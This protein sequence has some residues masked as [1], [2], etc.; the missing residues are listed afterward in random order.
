MSSTVTFSAPNRD[1]HGLPVGSFGPAVRLIYMGDTPLLSSWSA[2]APESEFS[3]TPR[4]N[5]PRALRPRYEKNGT[6]RP[7]SST[8]AVTLIASATVVR[9]DIA[10]RA[11]L[12]LS[13]W[14]AMRFSAAAMKRPGSSELASAA[15]SESISSIS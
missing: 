3:S 4:T 9:P 13:R 2:T 8:C 1:H 15:S 5:S 12:S 6:A 11:A 10:S 14:P 7:Q